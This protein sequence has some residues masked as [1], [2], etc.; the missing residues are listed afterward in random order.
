MQADSVQR[1]PRATPSAYKIAEQCRAPA[2]CQD[3]QGWRELIIE[4][5]TASQMGN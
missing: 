3:T 4:H 1:A 2:L 5:R